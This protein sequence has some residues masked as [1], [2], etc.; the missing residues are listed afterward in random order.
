MTRELERLFVYGTLAPGRPNEH[1]L[2]ALEG[3]WEDATVRGTL[4]REGWGA[5]LGYPAIVLDDAGDEVAGAVFSS[6][7]LADHWE[8][9]DAFE[10]D[11][12]ERVLAPVT[13]ANGE[14]AQAFVYALRRT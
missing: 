1:V 13:L 7:D 4:H 9:L 2:A 5:S 10:G 3:T 14:R 6:V 12:Y 8:T 11:A